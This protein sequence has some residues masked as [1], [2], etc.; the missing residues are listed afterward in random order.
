MNCAYALFP[1][2]IRRSAL[3]RPYTSVPRAPTVRRAR[4]WS[5]F[6]PKRTTT[7]YACSTSPSVSFS[8]H[9]GAP[10]IRLNEPHNDTIY[11]LATGPVT[12]TGVAIMRISGPAATHA[13]RSLLSPKGKRLTPP[14]RTATLRTLYHP[15]TVEVLDRALV[16]YFPH[17]HSFTTEDVV[18]LHLHGS[19]AVIA[20]VTDAL[21]T[22]PPPTPR[23]AVRGEFTR[24]AF[25]NG[26]MDLVGVEALADLIAAETSSQRQ[27]AL[28]ALSGDTGAVVHGWRSRLVEA[29]AHVEAVLDFA[30]DVGNA[31]LQGLQSSMCTLL[32]EMTERLS[33]GR[34][35][36]I[37]RSGA[38]IALVGPPNAGKSSLLNAL[39]RRPAA[40]VSPTAGTTRDVVDVRMDLAGIAATVSDTAGLRASPADDVEAEG[41]RRARAAAVSADIIICVHDISKQDLNASMHVTHT[42]L[43]TAIDAN[44]DEGGDADVKPPHIIYVFNK[45]DLC[46]PGHIASFELVPPEDSFQTSIVQGEGVAELISRVEEVL[47]TRL[48]MANNFEADAAPVIT[49]AR[50]RHHVQNAV[51]ALTDFIKGQAP[52]DPSLRMPM[53]M[54]AEDLRTACKEVGAITGVIDAEEVL[55]II[56]SEFCIGK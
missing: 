45:T 35:A 33:S 55:D 37:V 3:L 40:I 2:C 44:I 28:R 7:P 24:R 15:Q 11:A 26:A 18:E 31:P 36:E 34:R 53:D 14:A 17:P 20:A 54:A 43:A 51:N 10:L 56:F 22:V 4:H 21:A 50:H 6:T 47:K 48:E 19:R 12:T 46:A 39:A 42:A 29:L 25:E 27:Q 52:E 13:L 32:E 5:S 30:D 38:R 16:I 41:M 8:Q 1:S 9:A 49:R 23:P